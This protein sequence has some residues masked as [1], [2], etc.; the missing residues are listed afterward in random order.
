MYAIGAAGIATVLVLVCAVIL[1]R[2]WG[3]TNRVIVQVFLGLNSTVIGLLAWAI[4]E[5]NRLLPR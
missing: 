2:D 5:L 4:I 1:A 3:I